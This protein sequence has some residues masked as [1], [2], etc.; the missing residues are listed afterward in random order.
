MPPGA[1]G[2]ARN[3]AT[4]VGSP[5]P[6]PAPMT[7]GSSHGSWSRTHPRATTATRARRGPASVTA[8]TVARTPPV[9]VSDASPT[10][11]QVDQG[12]TRPGIRPVIRPGSAGLP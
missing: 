8:V 6:P 9:A 5:T 3:A 1:S 10:Q 7:D 2:W 4:P 12:G 11:A